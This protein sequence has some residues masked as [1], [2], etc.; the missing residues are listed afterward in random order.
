MTLDSKLSALRATATVQYHIHLAMSAVTSQTH[1]LLACSSPSPNWMATSVMRAVDNS[2]IQ[3]QQATTRLYYASPR[4]KGCKDGILGNIRMH[5]D[6]KT[7]KRKLVVNI[8]VV[9]VLVA[10]KD[11]IQGSNI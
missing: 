11:R 1:H 9:V 5:N 7:T 4:C 6:A 8:L 2:S 10:N 3:S